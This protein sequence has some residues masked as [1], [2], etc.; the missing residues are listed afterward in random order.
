MKKRKNKFRDP[1]AEPQ[2]N[3]SQAD[4]Q[5]ADSRSIG[6]DPRSKEIK[7]IKLVHKAG[8]REING[9]APD[10]TRDALTQKPFACF[11]PYDVPREFF[12]SEVIAW[13][14]LF[15]HRLWAMMAGN[16]TGAKLNEK[17]GKYHLEWRWKFSTSEKIR[18]Y[19]ELVDAIDSDEV[20]SI[21]TVKDCLRKSDKSKAEAEGSEQKSQDKPWILNADSNLFWFC[22]LRQKAGQ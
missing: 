21:Y 22:F 15:S 3:C 2:S 11:I 7:F 16:L 17:W 13:S 8:T 14:S 12:Y 6:V 1:Q 9:P 4:P 5:Q 20:K 18:T 19:A 10:S